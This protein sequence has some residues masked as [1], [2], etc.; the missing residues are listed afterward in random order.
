LIEAAERAVTL[1]KKA[2]RRRVMVSNP[3]AAH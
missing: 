2:G 1:A 3:T